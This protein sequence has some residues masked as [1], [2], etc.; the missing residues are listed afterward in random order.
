MLAV[1]Y[2]LPLRLHPYF[3]K[4]ARRQ[5]SRF[6]RVYWS[7]KEPKGLAVIVSKEVSNLSTR[8]NQIKRTI[9]DFFRHH[10]SKISQI[11]IVIAVKPNIKEI[12]KQQLTNELNHLLTTISL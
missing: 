1:R 5:E 3:F 8:R 4:Q 2:R 7:E 9:S 10:L 6:F 11:G 12:S